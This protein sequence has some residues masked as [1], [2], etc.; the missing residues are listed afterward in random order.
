MVSNF[1][2]TGRG[3]SASDPS[4]C[5]QCSLS[6]FLSWHRF[7]PAEMGVPRYPLHPSTSPPLLTWQQQ[8]HR[9]AFM[10][11][12]FVLAVTSLT[13]FLPSC[14]DSFT[15]DH[16][17]SQCN[18]SSA[19]VSFAAHFCSFAAPVFFAIT[20]FSDPSFPHPSLYR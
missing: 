9:I 20:Y 10:P 6:P 12:V 11:V 3:L 4:R 16:F 1:P 2:L 14:S 5:H 17:L 15:K 19:L 8:P 7:L 13:P 18:G